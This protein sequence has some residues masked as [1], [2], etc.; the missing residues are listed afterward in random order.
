[1]C[2]CL[3]ETLIVFYFSSELA[4]Y[5]KSGAC[6]SKSGAFLCIGG[7]DFDSCKPVSCEFNVKG[8]SLVVGPRGGIDVYLV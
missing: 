1:M 7:K 6:Y 4:S 5:S 3:S 2:A 8:K